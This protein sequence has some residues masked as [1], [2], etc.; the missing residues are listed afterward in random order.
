[1]VRWPRGLEYIGSALW[2]TVTYTSAATTRL[3]LFDQKRANRSL[4]NLPLA[5][6]LPDPQ[7]FLIQSLRF[8]PVVRPEATT[9]AATSV[10]QTGTSDDVA[11]LVNTGILELRLLNK[12]YGQWPLFMLPS[13]GGV[14]SFFQT[15]D[16]DVVV[17]FA[18]NG[19][20]D[21]RNAYVLQEPLFIPP[22]T[23]IGC[24]L[25]WPA[26]LTLALGNTDLKVI[27]DGQMVRPI[28]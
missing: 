7:G 18:V 3:T 5:G 24:T 14:W 6:T 23:E 4:G 20:P 25:S 21:A 15:G 26:A 2:D 16:I 27:F 22:V 13:G 17:D 8:Y 1:M 11:Q 12:E 10:T 9:A 28:Q 19:V